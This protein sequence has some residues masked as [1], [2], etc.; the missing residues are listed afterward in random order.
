M[1]RNAVIGCRSLF[2]LR[3]SSRE[4][5]FSMPKLQGWPSVRDLATNE[6]IFI[7][8]CVKPPK[9]L[10]RSFVAEIAFLLGNDF[11]IRVTIL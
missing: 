6:N 9:A 11:E 1:H 10:I 7:K 2:D 4:N 5:S 3:V 8:L